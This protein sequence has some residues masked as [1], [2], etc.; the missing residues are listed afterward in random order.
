MNDEGRLA[1]IIRRSAFSVQRSLVHWAFARFYREFAWTYDV[2]AA[3]VSSNRWREWTLAALPYLHGRVLELGCGTG[4]LQRALAGQER[5]PA[6][7][8][9]DVSPQMLGLARRKL[10]STG[11]VIRLLRADARALPFPPA[12]FDT[13]VATFPSEY[14]VAPATLAEARRVLR[15]GGRLAVVLAAQLTA[16]GLYERFVDLAYR[17]TLQ[18]SPRPTPARTAPSPARYALSRINLRLQ[19]LWAG[20]TRLPAVERSLQRELARAGFSA[21]QLWHPSAGSRVE[22]VLAYVLV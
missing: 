16:D 12:V 4:N 17:L 18:R 15:P 11:A 7:I 19:R 21:R 13:L 2:V 3:L 5:F 10:E 8:G 9:L 20:Q 22:I 14:I 6:P 1:A